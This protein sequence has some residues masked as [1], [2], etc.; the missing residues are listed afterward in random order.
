ML[1]Q[2]DQPS[3][4]SPLSRVTCQHSTLAISRSADTTIGYVNTHT[5]IHTHTQTHTHTNTYTQTYTC[6]RANTHTHTHTCTYT[7]TY[8]VATLHY[9]PLHVSLYMHFA[10]Q[11]HTLTLPPATCMFVYTCLIAIQYNLITHMRS[12]FLTS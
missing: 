4:P 8:N 9:T 3:I 7:H 6:K 12:S 5:Y 11:D 1:L 10:K 2:L